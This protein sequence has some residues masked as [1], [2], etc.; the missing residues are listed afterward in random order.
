MAPGF[1]Q[2]TLTE[3]DVSRMPPELRLCAFRYL[4]KCSW[5]E[6]GGTKDE[7]GEIAASSREMIGVPAW[8]EVHLRRFGQVVKEDSHG[9]SVTPDERLGPPPGTW[10]PVVV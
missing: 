6:D 4:T 3:S 2:V 1:S 5:K 7:N 9:E 10:R 8:I